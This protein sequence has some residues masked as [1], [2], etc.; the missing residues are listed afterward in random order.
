MIMTSTYDFAEPGFILIDKVNEMNNNWFC[1]NIRATNPCGEQPLPAVRLLPAGLDQPDQVRAQPV[2]RQGPNSTGRNSARS[3]PSSR[4][5]ST[6]WSRSTACRWKQQRDEIMR[7]RRHGMGFLGLGSTLTMLCMSYGEQDSV[8]FTERSAARWP[9]RLAHR[10]WIWRRK[11]VRHRSWNEDFEVTEEMLRKRPE[12]RRDG[13]Q[14]GDKVKGK[15]LHAKYSRYMQQRGRGRAGAGRRAG[16]AWRALHPPQLH[17]TDRHDLPVAGQQCQQRHRAQ[18]RAPLFPQRDPRRPQDQGKGGRVLVRAAGL[19]RTG[20]SA[21]PAPRCDG[22]DDA[23]AG[24]LH[25]RRRRHAPKQHVDIQA[26]AQKWVDSS[27]SKTANVPTDYP[28]EDFKDIYLYAYEKGLKGCTT[29]RFNPE[30]FQGVLVKEQGSGEHHLRVHPGGWHQWSSLKGNDEV[31][32]DGEIHTAAN[33]YD[34]LKEGLLRQVLSEDQIPSNRQHEIRSSNMAIQVSTRR[35]SDYRVSVKDE[36]TEQ[37][38]RRAAQ[39]GRSR[40]RRQCG[41]AAREARAPGHAGRLD[42]QGQDA[43]VRACPVCHHQRHHSQSRTPST[44]CA[45]PSRS[46]S[47]PRTWTTSSGSWR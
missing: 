32:Y 21:R 47:T 25:H 7:K 10:R 44:S 42:L 17:R 26:A 40:Q 30:A 27:I 1:E 13:Y 20:Q 8:E 2:Y 37:D 16:R 34:A 46:S 9:D 45:A 14:P 12:M 22:A 18:F 36:P 3:S 15:V 41:P 33:L 39:V 43:A 24:L 31:E 35:S 4:A 11:R 29:F 23:A 6:T 28:F 19:S 5:C 38:T